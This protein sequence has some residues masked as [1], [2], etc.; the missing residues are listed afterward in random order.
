M[1]PAIPF[2]QLPGPPKSATLLLCYLPDHQHM[3]FREGEML[4][5]TC[6]TKMQS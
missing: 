6:S 5:G 3:K 4:K 1:L 2:Y